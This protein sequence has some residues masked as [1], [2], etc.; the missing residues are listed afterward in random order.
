MLRASENEISCKN[1][2]ESLFISHRIGKNANVAEGPKIQLLIQLIAFVLKL[3]LYCCYQMRMAAERQREIQPTG[4]V[5]VGEIDHDEI[6]HIEVR[7]R[8]FI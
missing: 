6:K 8:I 3:I 2:T 1:L 5:F 7:H 4:N